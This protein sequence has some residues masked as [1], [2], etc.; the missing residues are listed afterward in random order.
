MERRSML[1]YTEFRALLGRSCTSQIEFARMSGVTPRAV[2]EWATGRKNPPKWAVQL[3]IA[4]DH[5]TATGM[6]C[7]L[8]AAPSFAWW[9][10]LGIQKVATPQAVS[11]ARSKLAKKYHPDIGGNTEAMQRVN[12]AA[13]AARGVR[14]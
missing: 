2:N 5:L 14:R 10:T 3:A 1:L 11:A 7:A 13:D 9:E 4:I 8:H 12:S 6:S